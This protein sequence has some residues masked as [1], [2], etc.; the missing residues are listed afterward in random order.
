MKSIKTLKVLYTALLCLFWHA[1]AAGFTGSEPAPFTVNFDGV[2]EERIVESVSDHEGNLYVIGYYRQGTEPKLSIFQDDPAAL[3]SGRILAPGAAQAN[4]YTLF[5]ANTDPQRSLRELFVARFNWLGELVWV[6]TAGGS[7]SDAATGIA[8]DRVNRRLIISGYITGQSAWFQGLSVDAAAVGQ[9]L[10]GDT[11]RNLFVATMD[12]DGNWLHVETMPL[13]FTL[14]EADGSTPVAGT[15]MSL[16]FGGEDHD[17][18]KDLVIAVDD[19][20]SS[21]DTVVYVTSQLRETTE[22][23]VMSTP[24][25][26]GATWLGYLGLAGKPRHNLLR[27][28]NVGGNG[29]A[30]SAGDWSFVAK[31]VLQRNL[32]SGDETWN[33]AWMSKLDS[34]AM[35]APETAGAAPALSCEDASPG[36]QTYV[37]PSGGA[38]P[39]SGTEH[40]LTVDYQSFGGYP[41]N[42]DNNRSYGFDYIDPLQ[43]M[44]AEMTGM[45]MQFQFNRGQNNTEMAWEFYL[46]NDPSMGDNRA[47]MQNVDFTRMIFRIVPTA[48]AAPYI[49]NLGPN[50]ASFEDPESGLT[51]LQYV[52]IPGEPF[53][54]ESGD[55]IPA[56]GEV[57]SDT[58]LV[59]QLLTEHDAVLT[60]F[61]ANYR[62]E[63]FRVDTSTYPAD[64]LIDI[65]FDFKPDYYSYGGENN[66]VV[67][68]YGGLT[69]MPHMELYVDWVLR[70]RQLCQRQ[71]VTDL[72]VDPNQGLTSP[73]YFSGHFRSALR[74]LGEVRQ[75]RGG[76]ANGFVGSINKDGA[77]RFVST[78]DALSALQ[79]LEINTVNGSPQLIGV[80]TL[81]GGSDSQVTLKAFQSTSDL[82][83]PSPAEGSSATLLAAVDDSG[84]WG[85]ADTSLNGA[86]F[87]LEKTLNNEWVIG[88]AAYATGFALDEPAGADAYLARFNA[89]TLSGGAGFQWIK[90]EPEGNPADSFVRSLHLNNLG[91][92]YTLG[93]TFSESGT[94]TNFTQADASNADRLFGIGSVLNV[95]DPASGNFLP[96]FQRYHEYIVGDRI[97]PQVGGV[98]S[99]VSDSLRR[100]IPATGLGLIAAERGQ[101]NMP[102]WVAQ[103][104]Y[105][106]FASGPKDQAIVLWPT[107]DAPQPTYQPLVGKAIKIRWPT[108]A[109]GLQNYIYHAPQSAMWDVLQGGYDSQYDAIDIP[110]V[111]L[112]LE[113]A[114]KTLYGMTY[115]ATVNEVN[116]ALQSGTPVA[117]GDGVAINDG[118]LTTTQNR[119]TALIF[120]D[121]D[122]PTQGHPTIKS[123]RSHLWLE[124]ANLLN[125]MP[126]IGQPLIPPA[127]AMTQR[128]AYVST[129]LARY[130]TTEPVYS[131]SSREGQVFPVN[132][133]GNPADIAEWLTV[134][135][136]QADQQLNLEWPFHFGIYQPEWPD[137]GL[138]VLTSQLGSEGLKDGELQSF[139]G[140]SQV[141]NPQIYVQNDRTLPG[142]NP[143]EEHAFRQFDGSLDRFV[144]HA[145]RNDLNH[146][147]SNGTIDTS[148]PYVLVRYQPT[149][150]EQ[151]YAYR[152]YRVDFNHPQDYPDFELSST[153]G[154][155]VSAP[156]YLVNRV[157]AET[158]PADS[159]SREAFLIDYD[160]KVW[161]RSG[162]E[163]ISINYHY[164][165]ESGFWVDMD[166]DGQSD[167]V[168]TAAFL[169]V[170]NGTP[171][172]PLTT[173][174]V[175]Q[176]DLIPT[177]NI[178]D[179]LITAQDGLPAV[180]N[181]KSLRVIYDDN[182][183]IDPDDLSDVDRADNATVRLFNYTAE[184]V[185][186]LPGTVASTAR[187]SDES[188]WFIQLA[189]SS[190]N[191]TDDVVLRARARSG[192]VGV[193][194]FPQLPSDLRYRLRYRWFDNSQSGYFFFRGG[195]F[196]PTSGQDLTGAA[197]N[198][199]SAMHLTNVITPQER[200]TLKRMDNQSEDPFANET[201]VD[202]TVWD[203]LVD[204]LYVKSRNPNDVAVAG[205]AQ[206]ALMIG[207][208]QDGSSNELQHNIVPESVAMTTAFAKAPGRVVLAE[209]ID[210]PSESNE[211]VKLHVIDVIDPIA[212]GSINVLR[213]ELNKLDKRL[214]VR[215]DLD[216]GGRTEGMEFEWYWQPDTATDP[217][218]GSS[219]EP[220][221][222]NPQTGELD[223]AWQKLEG[224]SLSIYIDGGRPLL[225]DGWLVSRYK[226]L[227]TAADPSGNTWSEFTGEAVTLGYP[228]KPAFIAGW[229]KR[230]IEDI[231]PF[232][233][234][235]S[236]FYN[237]ANGVIS[238]TSMLQQAGPSYRGAVAMNAEDGNLNEVGLI[239]LYT[240]V[241]DQA[242]DL[243]LNQSPPIVDDAINKQLMFATSRIAD[244]Y[245]LLGNEA[246]S[247]A[248]DP[249]IGTLSSSGDAAYLQP[250]EFAF[251]YSNVVSS[252]LEEEMAMLRGLPDNNV[253]TGNR[254]LW[255]TD[256]SEA[257]AI[258]AQVYGLTVTGENSLEQEAQ[259]QYPQGH[260]DAWGHYLTAIKH[261]YA[262]A[263]HP[264]YDWKPLTENTTI[265]GVAVSVDYRDEVRFARAA[266]AKARTGARLVDLAF[267][268]EYTHEPSA[269]W[270]GYKDSVPNRAWGMDG[271]AR[272]AG[273]G[274]VLDW[275]LGNALLP[276]EDIPTEQGIER[277]DRQTVAELKEVSAAF[278]EIENLVAQADKGNNP[279]GLDADTIPFDISPSALANG[280]SHFEQIYA[281]ALQ[282]S[283]NSLEIFSY[284]NDL[285]Q[286]IRVGNID[287]AAMQ[288]LDE[289]KER[290]FKSRL[291][292]LLGYP[293]QGNIGPGKLYPTGYNGPDIYQFMYIDSGLPSGTGFPPSRIST[294]DLSIAG[295]TECPEFNPGNPL[296]CEHYNKFLFDDDHGVD[297]LS[298]HFN[299]DANNNL[300]VN[301]PIVSEVPYA[302]VKPSASWGE[303]AAPGRIQL[304]LGEMQQIQAR[305]NTLYSEH[306]VLLEKIQSETDLL[307]AIYNINLDQILLDGVNTGTYNS[308][309][310]ESARLQASAWGLQMVGE[311]VYRSTGLLLSGFSTNN[312]F[313]NDVTWPARLGVGAAVVS[314]LGIVPSAGVGAA[315]FIRQGELQR[316]S[317]KDAIEVRQS[318]YPIE[319]QRQLTVIENLLNEEVIYR[320]K[321]VELQQELDNAGG[322]YQQLVAESVRLMEER[323]MFR[324]DVANRTTNDRYQ[325]MTYRVF[326]NEALQ[327]Y[328]AS[329]D[330]AARYTYLAAKAFDYETG[331]LSDDASDQS[332]YED[333]VKKRTLGEF[334]PDSGLPV[335]G[336]N[337]L[338]TPL[339]KMAA[340]YVNAESSYGLLD[341]LNEQHDFSL[342]SEAFRIAASDAGTAKWQQLLVDNWVPNLWD[343]EEFRRYA[344]PPGV[345]PDDGPIQGVVLRFGTTIQAGKNLF[346]WTAG[347][348][349]ATYSATRSATKFYRVGLHFEDYPDELVRTPY[350]YLIPTGT[351]VLR[352]PTD[353]TQLRYYNVLEQVVPVPTDLVNGNSAYTNDDWIPFQDVATR[354][355]NQ[356]RRRYSET[357]VDVS[358]VFDFDNV[359]TDGR[360]VGRSVWNT[361]W[362]LIIPDSSLLGTGGGAGVDILING[363]NGNPANRGISDIRLV[364]DT[365][366][367]SGN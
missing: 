243:S 227:P 342:R 337:G 154:R 185:S 353:I 106:V 215:Q 207:M 178:G 30:S 114:N 181:M 148:D 69:R 157:S 110:P 27:W 204:A 38:S 139:I 340:A 28:T 221:I 50:D 339:A 104:D 214:I 6:K 73:V 224:D 301:F 134:S 86:A 320:Y 93:S 338:A 294:L 255:N 278:S 52:R 59:N 41:V 173:T 21:S 158:H 211:G 202:V 49:A 182:D 203:D 229:V 333:L 234:R 34:S 194:D 63:L 282:A 155:E 77:W 248:M 45:T 99:Q 267:R 149:A 144:V 232:E 36:T 347:G 82:D 344:V 56:P 123:V 124:P 228:A 122:N 199:P 216:F 81:V 312:G 258:Y 279:F 317:Y 283:K 192:E 242:M 91:T 298:T 330:L 336:V 160:N 85:W 319:I 136:Y 159:T 275:A 208:E 359:N 345:S 287:N 26:E 44:N 66:F 3:D 285:T 263:L 280:Q 75:S 72:V 76:E 171:G 22:L 271:W 281:R 360:L 355:D 274:A 31:L 190:G 365:Y 180:K 193:F 241:L 89:A 175:N 141:E 18:G 265:A 55:Y 256:S 284:A 12:L 246:Y 146:Y 222:I 188:G 100:T 334:S 135:W 115:L 164:S 90:L 350:A 205:Q 343:V 153:A 143:N 328:R 253:L 169:D 239:E 127:G 74:A 25:G 15:L 121:G 230:V 39:P 226:G 9:G 117:F 197:A 109:E 97:A 361:D 118:L 268:S 311:F 295:L 79:A 152:V 40:V 2:G 262:L 103:S 314:A 327:K 111:D 315:Q 107:V 196:D 309:S 1:T 68:S 137:D 120:F 96:D 307:A 318:Q 303:R 88:G 257:E 235:Y 352:S 351:D 138:I 5:T 296:N 223:S 113:S 306:Q 183:N 341:P 67:R 354:W 289:E 132:E 147:S 259:I 98:E 238:Y 187:G 288:V 13:A 168:E 42:T 174:Y 172:Q 304:Q 167:E 293:Y 210:G 269:Q 277:I 200:D 176:W 233:Q 92:L 195:V 10:D 7:G 71:T 329:F 94:V 201:D 186:D 323:S 237:D 133:N 163:P 250:T 102:L 300:Q 252:L 51:W 305:L 247:D 65:E 129:P 101:P 326:R 57:F 366:S 322:V 335:A 310:T 83:I 170:R 17:L 220:Q 54:I 145:I 245:M 46:E 313:A 177:I 218:T 64:T 84:V 349:D 356:N 37:Q 142:Y 273:Q 162:N 331:L 125:S 48:E 302:F 213:N 206:D 8:F 244:L 35:P 308:L 316:A 87:D 151:D 112:T 130:D 270:Q 363:D 209:N 32:Q 61:V 24:S 236:N 20:A 260:G 357:P 105:S 276:Y 299:L 346:G 321:A 291:I 348:Q 261:Y 324:R 225:S 231:N 251:N 4:P 60:I 119:M 58:E 47:M 161:S 108:V 358:P 156:R 53:E 240:T 70:D 292:E 95:V 14:T 166:G 219:T 16:Q 179:T 266:A 33:W 11:T 43:D 362:V 140:L 62:I 264:S 332:F 189:A 19:S 297:D 29:V 364:F 128:N 126:A 191:S 249:T 290:D 325:D 131:R 184:I 367:F 78:V 150:P 80:G 217:D 116:G 212:K 272:R 165:V 254:L 286:Q 198:L 23:E